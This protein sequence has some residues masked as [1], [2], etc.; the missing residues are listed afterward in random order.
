MSHAV[1]PVHLFTVPTFAVFLSPCLL[2]MFP[3]MF[4]KKNDDPNWVVTV[5]G[6]E[7]GKPESPELPAL[8]YRI[9]TSGILLDL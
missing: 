5:G 8:V 9:E 4:L 2:L 3:E 7:L 1:C 6:M